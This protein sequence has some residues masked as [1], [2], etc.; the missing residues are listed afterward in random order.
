L[1]VGGKGNQGGSVSKLSKE[2]QE[3]IRS[4]LREAHAT[5][6]ALTQDIVGVCGDGLYWAVEY[7][8]KG[9]SFNV[10]TS[11]RKS[12]K[13]VTGW[14]PIL[15][16]AADETAGKVSE[17]GTSGTPHAGREVTTT[18]FF[19]VSSGLRHQQAALELG[20]KVVKAWNDAYRDDQH[21]AVRWERCVA[22][23]GYR[24]ECSCG[25]EGYVYDGEDGPY[26]DPRARHNS[27]R[28]AM[29]GMANVAACIHEASQRIRNEDDV[30]RW[31]QARDLGRARI[32]VE[33]D[34]QA[35]ARWSE[36]VRSK[37]AKSEAIHGP[38]IGC[39]S[40]ADE[41]Y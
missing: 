28:D 26:V 9:S 1:D 40:E 39:Q 36:A 7:G 14:Q 18:T 34:K 31:G 17:A 20:S 4:L 16:R 38:R 22:S 2:T 30:F 10:P 27:L 3:A 33:A 13:D 23:R 11:N 5:H 24:I 35:S 6:P 21:V 8:A 12:S 29:E 37:L 15:R 32:G 41:D 25:S 19:D